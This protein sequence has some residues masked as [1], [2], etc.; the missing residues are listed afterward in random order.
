MQRK[1]GRVKV[2]CAYVHDL[3]RHYRLQEST[4]TTLRASSNAS[5]YNAHRRKKKISALWVASVGRS[6]DKSNSKFCRNR[7][8]C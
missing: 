2:L 5:R 1:G 7:Q 6:E 8:T 4:C 3:V